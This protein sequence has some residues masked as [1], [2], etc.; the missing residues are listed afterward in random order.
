MPEIIRILCSAVPA[1]F[2]FFVAIDYR[3]FGLRVYDR[4]ESMTSAVRNPRMTPDRFRIVAGIGSLI[5][6]GALVNDLAHL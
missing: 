6:F 2:F 5:G 1:F 4:L 3:N